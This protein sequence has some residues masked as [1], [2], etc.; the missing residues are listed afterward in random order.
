MAFKGKLKQKTGANTSEIL[1]PESEADVIIYSNTS[2]GLTATDVQG[3][4]DEIVSSGVGVTGVKGNAES[5]YRT[6]QV[7]LTPANIGAEAAFTD[8]DAI[9]A[10]VSNDVVTINK[11]VKQTSG[12]ISVDSSA[13][14][15]TLAK[16]AK[17]GTYSDLS[18]K[19]TIG[20]AS[21]V[22]KAGGTLK[23]VFS[24]NA[25]TLVEV[26][27]TASDLGLSSALRYLGETT[28]I[29][30]GSTT[31][32]ITI[33]S[34]SITAINGDVVTVGNKE[35]LW[36]ESLAIPAWEEL[37]DE[38]SHALKSITISAGTGL[39]GGGTLEA[40]RT[41]SLADAYGDAKNPY[42][43]KTKN[44]VLAAPS[45]QSGTPSFRELVKSDLPDLSDTYIPKPSTAV[46]S[47]IVPVYYDSADNELKAG[48][49]Y[50][51]GTKVSVNGTD[52]GGSGASIYAPTSAPTAPSSNTK[53]Y[54][55][56]SDSTSSLASEKISSKVYI[57]DD[58]LYS[59]DAAVLTG[60]QTIT[61]S[62]DVTGSG[63]TS[64]TATLANSGVTAGTYS[65]VSVNAKG[66]VTA[67]AQLFKVVE[68]GAST[69]D[70]ATNGLYF[71][72]DA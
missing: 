59:N 62:G 50:A 63:T 9:V 47:A 49:E 28:G 2:S 1:H 6:G 70:V 32:P 5:N 27:I 55:V 12:A 46:G 3:A 42:G 10:S 4:I 8:G 40:N 26:N 21:L 29:T 11:K 43:S 48:T 19:P 7:N 51:G 66:L 41:L 54:V 16:V 44:Y 13:G 34:D 64:I 30:D 71:E 37:G 35:F 52:K 56:G 57:K 18:G 45:A 38:S 24:A 61:L 33:G 67:G 68:N 36:N 60:N 31:N 20:D 14:D 15:I 17:T 53:A 22:I 65:A 23:G 39:T 69:A 25:T 72:K 58:K